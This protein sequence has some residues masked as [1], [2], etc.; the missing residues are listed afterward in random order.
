MK[1]KVSISFLAA[2]AGAALAGAYC[3]GMDEQTLWWGWLIVA[4]GALIG[5][6]IIEASW[7]FKAKIVPPAIVVGVATTMTV[8]CA[9]MNAMDG[10]AVNLPFVT[11]MCGIAFV[12]GAIVVLIKNPQTPSV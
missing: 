4:I 8:V 9:Q 11:M 10:E 3:A 6:G 2:L 1:P 7:P 12:F 5:A